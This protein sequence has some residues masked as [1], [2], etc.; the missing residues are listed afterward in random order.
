M[1]HDRT[2]PACDAERGATLVRGHYLAHL[3]ELLL[4]LD[5]LIHP[6]LERLLHL[7]HPGSRG[8]VG[9]GEGLEAPLQLI[10][11][12][13]LGEHDRVALAG[14]LLQPPPLA[15]VV[16]G[17]PVPWVP[18]A[19]KAHAPPGQEGAVET[20]I[21]SKAVPGEEAG[22]VLRRPHVDV[23]LFAIVGGG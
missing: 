16:H 14:L 18:G 6:L 20:E 9:R 23:R 5:E 13:E 12:V 7:G 2:D 19:A 10:L 4:L 3:L 11:A 21:A 8:F 15:F 22:P 1:T 17:E